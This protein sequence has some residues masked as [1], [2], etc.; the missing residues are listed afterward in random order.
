MVSEAVNATVGDGG[1][2]FQEVNVGDGF[3]SAFGA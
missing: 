3:R 1:E 2:S